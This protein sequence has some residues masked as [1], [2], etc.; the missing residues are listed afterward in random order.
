[1]AR[2]PQG[3]ALT[4]LILGGVAFFIGW[5]PILGFL[6]G[7]AAII[8]GLVALGKRQP[9]YFA[10]PGLSLG[11]VAALTSLIV[12][13]VLVVVPR[14]A[15]LDS[16]LPQPL[17]PVPSAAAPQQSADGTRENPLPVGSTVV[18]DEW[19]ITVGAPTF[20]ATA[21]VTGENMFNSEPE[22]GNEYAL[23]PITATYKGADSKTLMLQVDFSFVTAEGAAWDA[24]LILIV[25]GELDRSQELY[26][27][28]TV[29]G[30]VGI[31]I[32]AGSG[33]TGLMRVQAGLF[34]GTEVFVALQ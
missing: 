24:P 32:P 16:S 17:V 15:T 2:G 30:N 11:A 25:P 4:A 13:F 8:L 5:V 19:D 31:E 22:A 12:T 10:V 33:P 34:G 3:L 27:G 7:A 14:P 1:V 28:A 9:K 23:F 29:S 18:L 20:G 21:A 6:L 26:T